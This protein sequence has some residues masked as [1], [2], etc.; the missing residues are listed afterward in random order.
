[1]KAATGNLTAYLQLFASQ[2]ENSQ[3]WIIVQTSALQSMVGSS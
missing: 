3:P 1:M 2:Q